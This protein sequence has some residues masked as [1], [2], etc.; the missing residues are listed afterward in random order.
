MPENGNLLRAIQEAAIPQAEKLEAEADALAAKATEL[1]Y[2][3]FGLRLL[4]D[5]AGRIK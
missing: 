3:A 1:R 2:R 5:E 4:A